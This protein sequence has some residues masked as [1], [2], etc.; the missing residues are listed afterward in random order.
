M[1]RAGEPTNKHNAQK[2]LK[3]CQ[4]NQHTNESCTHSK[5]S[6]WPTHITA[7]HGHHPADHLHWQQPTPCLLYR[8]QHHIHFSVFC[9]AAHAGGKDTKSPQ[10]YM[11]LKL[12]PQASYGKCQTG[13]ACNGAL[14][15]QLIQSTGCSNQALVAVAGAYM[16]S[17]RLTH[18]Q[19]QT[20]QL[21]RQA[22]KTNHTRNMPRNSFRTPSVGTP[23]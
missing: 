15:S 16:R 19:R 14:E 5:N 11:Q 3:M 1:V 13:V 10:G 6:K 8:E 4:Q 21:T 22:R 2:A 12:R 18:V 7:G 17:S 23:G 20:P 9:T